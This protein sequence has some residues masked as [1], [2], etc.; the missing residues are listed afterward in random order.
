VTIYPEYTFH[1]STY[2]RNYLYPNN[3]LSVYYFYISC[4]YCLFFFLYCVHYTCMS[5]VLILFCVTLLHLYFLAV[6]YFYSE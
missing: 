1:D 5:S 3:R 4:I 6:H 2:M